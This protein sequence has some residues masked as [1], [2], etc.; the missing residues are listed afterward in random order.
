MDTFTTFWPA[1]LLT[2]FAGLSTGIGAVLAFF[3]VGTT[4]GCSRSDWASPPG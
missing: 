2:L 1:F 4:R 3:P